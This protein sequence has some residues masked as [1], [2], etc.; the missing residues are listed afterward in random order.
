MTVNLTSKVGLRGQ[1]G[2]DIASANNAVLVL[3]GDYFD[4]TGAVTINTLSATGILPG[5]RITLQF[6]GAPTVA[7]ATAGTG[8]QFQLAGAGNFV[9]SADDT[10]EVVYDGTFW[11]EV[12]RTVI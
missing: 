3:D 10:L 9:A 7:H 5:T 8:A 4:V 6:D 1:K 12:S 11:R 2:S